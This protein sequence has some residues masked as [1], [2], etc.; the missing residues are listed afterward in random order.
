MA[1]VRFPNGDVIRFPDGTPDEVVR[2]VSDEHWLKVNLGGGMVE[3]QPAGTPAMRVPPSQERMGPMTTGASTET[4]PDIQAEP[5]SRTKPLTDEEIGDRP[6][7]GPLPS[8]GQKAAGSLAQGV[9]HL[10]Y[11][12]VDFALA[13]PLLG[14]FFSEQLLP[15]DQPTPV[16]DALAKGR[17]GV[18]EL[19][20]RMGLGHRLG[21]GEVRGGAAG[22]GDI[23]GKVAGFGVE[24]APYVA[25]EVATAGGVSLP[26]AKQVFERVLTKAMARGMERKAAEAVAKEAA[27]IARTGAAAT[28]FG[29]MGAGAGIEKGEPAEAAKGFAESAAGILAL[30]AAGKLFGFLTRTLR[31]QGF[32]PKAAADKAKVYREA[33]IDMHPDR[34]GPN[35]AE[36]IMREEYVK[37]LQRAI[38]GDDW[39]T[40]DRIISMWKR[41][42]PPPDLEVEAEIAGRMLPKDTATAQALRTEAE[43]VR[44]ET[45][46]AQAAKLEREREITRQAEEQRR[47]QA[48]R[49]AELL[50]AMETEGEPTQ[51]ERIRRMADDLG[52]R[53]TINEVRNLLNVQ[54]REEARELLNAALPE[55]AQ[56]APGSSEAPERPPAPAEPAAEFAKPQEPQGAQPEAIP[57]ERRVDLVRRRRVAE[58]S[59][60][61]AKREL[62]VDDRIRDQHGIEIGNRRAYVEAEHEAP[63]DIT[64]WY[65]VDS[66]GWWNDH[67]SEA[68]GDKLLG[69]IAEES[70]AIREEMGD[71]VRTVTR[72]GGDEFAG[73]FPSEQ[74]AQ[75]F[76]DRLNK[77][78][79][80][81]QLRVTLKDGTILTATPAISHGVGGDYDRAS[82]AGHEHKRQREQE[83][84]RAPKGR[85]PIDLVREASRAGEPPGQAGGPAAAAA[86]EPVAEGEG[87]PVPRAEV[88]AVST[89]P[90]RPESPPHTTDPNDPDFDLEASNRHYEADQEWYRKL[91]A[92]SPEEAARVL[93][94][95]QARLYLK[96]FGTVENFEKSHRF[97]IAKGR[98]DI[99]A[100][101]REEMERL[102]AQ[103]HHLHTRVYPTGS[104]GKVRTDEA[105]DKAAAELL[106]RML[107]AE[108]KEAPDAEGLRGDEGQVRPRGGDELRR[109]AGEG[110][111]DLQREAPE[112]PR[113]EAPQAREGRAE[114]V[115]EAPEELNVGDA[116]RVMGSD[117][118][119]AD[120][121]TIDGVR[122][123]L[124]KAAR[125]KQGFVRVIDLD[126]GNVTAL[127]RFNVYDNARKVHEDAVAHVAPPE[128]PAKEPPE[129][130]KG[131]IIRHKGTGQQGPYKYTIKPGGKP[132]AIIDGEGGAKVW[133]PYDELE[134]VSGT[135]EGVP[136]PVAEKAAPKETKPETE[137]ES[138]RKTAV[139]ELSGG[140]VEQIEKAGY[141][142]HRRGDVRELTREE[143]IEFAG[144]AGPGTIRE[145]W[146][147]GITVLPP[148][149]PSAAPPRVDKKRIAAAKALRSQAKKLASKAQEALD[150]PRKTHTARYARQAESAMESAYADQALA[151]TMQAVA[152]KLESGE[153]TKLANVKTKAAVEALEKELRHANIEHER[154]LPADERAAREEIRSRAPNESD[155]EHATFPWPKMYGHNARYIARELSEML[156]KK[157]VPR[158]QIVRAKQLVKSWQNHAVRAGEDWVR[159]DEAWLD[160]M[161]DTAKLLKSDTAMLQS[162]VAHI[163]RL[164]RLG[165]ESTE[166]LRAAL[167]E[168]LDI[169]SEAKGVSEGKKAELALAGRKIP[170]FFPTPRSVIT[171]ML[172]R[173]DIKSTDRVLEPSAGKGDLADAMVAAGAG[174]GQKGNVDI[175]EFNSELAKI[176]IDKGYDVTHRDFLEYSV[177]GYDKIVMNPPFEKGQDIKHVQHAYRLLKPGGRVVSIMSEGPFFREDYESR[178]FRSWLEEVDGTSEKLPEGS[179]KEHELRKTGV[180]SRIVV[181]DKPKA[182]EAPA[183]AA[184]EPLAE[185]P[186]PEPKKPDA[187]RPTTRGHKT[188]ESSGTP[189]IIT[190]EAHELAK[191]RH[192]DDPKKQG[193]I[194]ATGARYFIQWPDGTFHGE[195]HA[196]LENALNP[197]FKHFGLTRDPAE[198]QAYF[199]EEAAKESLERIKRIGVT[200]RPDL[201][202]PIG[203]IDVVPNAD[204]RAA[205][206]QVEHEVDVKRFGFTKQQEAWIIEQLKENWPK[207]KDDA[208]ATLRLQI[209]GDGI[210]TMGSEGARDLFYTL[211][212]K[213]IERDEASSSNKLTA[214]TMSSGFPGMRRAAGEAGR[215]ETRKRYGQLSPAPLSYSPKAAWMGKDA[216][217]DV[218]G[219][220]YTNGHFLI[221]KKAVLENAP[222]NV[223]NEIKV[224]TSDPKHNIPTKAQLEKL[225]K[226]HANKDGT[227]AHLRG[228]R[229]SLHADQMEPIIETENGAI[230]SEF[231][232]SLDQ[233]RFLEDVTGFD[234]IRFNP[235]NAN[236]VGLWRGNEQV[237]IAGVR[238]TAGNRWDGTVNLEK[239]TDEVFGNDVTESA[240]DM[241]LIETAKD[242]FITVLDN[243]R[244]LGQPRKPLRKLEIP[245]AVK[246]DDPKIEERFQAAKGLQSE[247]KVAEMK[248]LL[249]S[250]SIIFRRHY[251]H[252]DVGKDSMRALMQDELRTLEAAERAAKPIT[253]I[254]IREITEGLDGQ[255]LDLFSRVI[256]LP[257]IIKDVEAGL[258]DTATEGEGKPLPFG[259]THPRFGDNAPETDITQHL[260]RLERIVAANSHVRAALDRRARY[261]RGLTEELVELEILDADVLADPR[262]YHRQVMKHFNARE[263]QWV[264]TGS[265]DVRIHTKGFMKRRVGGT[266]FNTAYQEAE[267]EWAS[268]AAAAIARKRT[269]DRLDELANIKG[270]LN[271]EARH[272]N[273]VNLVGGPENLARIHELRN[274]IAALREEI[275]NGASDVRPI[276]DARATE[277]GEL[278]PLIPYR[279]RIGEM[280]RFLEDQAAAGNLPAGPYPD[281]LG[282]LAEGKALRGAAEDK[283]ITPDYE[284]PEPERFFG[285]LKWLVEHGKEVADAEFKEMFGIP[286]TEADADAM[287]PQVP[288]LAFLKAVNEKN[289]FI[290]DRLG[291]DYLTWENLIPE[292]YV[293][294]QPKQ[295]ANVFRAL[296]I[297]ERAMQR[298][299][300]GEIELTPEQVHTVLAIGGMRPQWVIPEDLAKTLDEFHKYIDD[301]MDNLFR[302]A[303]STWKQTV[304]LGPTR[305]MKYNLNNM[306]GDADICVAFDPQIMKYFKDAAGDLWRYHVKG[307]RVPKPVQEEIDEAMEFGV[308][309]SGLTMTDIPD[310]SKSGA[311][312]ALINE[313]PNK[314][315]DLVDRYWKNVREFTV[316][317]ENILRLAAYR[318]MKERVL[319]SEKYKGAG[320]SRVDE[321]AP[322]T[323]KR[324]AAKLARDLVGDYGAI[325]RGGMWLRENLFSFWS[326]AEI[327]APRYVRLFKNLQYEEGGDPWATG[328][329]VAG[330][331]TKKVGGK[332]LKRVG[333]RVL[334]AHIVSGLVW[335]WNMTLFPD[336][337]REIRRTRRGLHVILGRNDETGEIHAIRFEGAL[338]D[339]LK[340]V[341]LSDWP[342][343][344]EDLVTGRAD[345]RDKVAEIPK[346]AA[347]RTINGV[348][349]FIKTPF[350]LIGGFSTY[351]SIFGEGRRGL[352]PRPIRDRTEHVVRTFGGWAGLDKL[353]NVVMGKPRRTTDLT[354]WQKAARWVEP[355]LVYRTDPREASYWAI[356]HEASKWAE[357]HLNKT[358]PVILHRSARSN[359]L[360]YYRKAL[361]WGDEKR[362]AKWLNEYFKEGGSP[363]G[364]EQSLRTQHPLYTIPKQHRGAFMAG[365]SKSDQELLRDAL[366]WYQSWSGK[367]AF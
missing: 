122:Y 225:W 150:Q 239:K 132:T 361:M 136:A 362:A 298:I 45:E 330:V 339:A 67:V 143:R 65:D 335:L 277:L 252:I 156:E 149:K 151:K 317:R 120:V 185:K 234:T 240:D 350:E 32:N 270:R 148:E 87:A 327:N 321:V 337:E 232:F 340:W 165:I 10:L 191:F 214:H 249:A 25:A 23:A 235:E 326:W 38:E 13:A 306:S 85:E 174:K 324:R 63:D 135:T 216:G 134:V 113:G 256:V 267:L 128:A 142:F 357:E 356:R 184:E 367:S 169:R 286:L 301:P 44:A 204:A 354:G 353:Y 217:L 257:D 123:E 316:W 36:R 266:D 71:R 69:V 319:G 173:A 103:G 164:H 76:A 311:F 56:K 133:I 101:V 119:V 8:A 167:E 5:P 94:Q 105:A 263:R 345:W 312:K 97:W 333:R 359:A 35:N 255:A 264:G 146:K 107:A 246:A 137:A 244:K 112:Q 305:A 21:G 129:L 100:R 18:H 172:E 73:R 162:D 220:W 258:Y 342:N 99:A 182:E 64:L 222:A 70:A 20:Q 147:A 364:L 39:K 126:S 9:T 190:V 302:W 223:K 22:V 292:G 79:Q 329:R 127:K 183:P 159:L 245:E 145:L 40:A 78:L 37:E 229:W 307:E 55:T 187:E 313:D 181:I 49:R 92:L 315:V 237:A 320:V 334:Q 57:E 280:K 271:A 1:E 293:A 155:L 84:L 283:F 358:S 108:K 203:L 131:T 188:P 60:E 114:G 215:P 27:Q 139:G 34:A 276:L 226:D 29:A 195:D 279:H 17:E 274:E 166:D 110:R 288:A 285:Y 322:L 251:P 341:G 247:G 75:E 304:L 31:S 154:S 284:D 43:Q 130:T 199:T 175:V 62:L 281:V 19:L 201:R 260:E 189:E 349:P 12:G 241:K 121:Q 366:I 262:Y 218:E 209:P 308:I 299:L 24:A 68:E 95:E 102:L 90:P 231:T 346:G 332:V 104:E 221:P 125:G 83:G 161:E 253:Y 47:P 46:Q 106:E 236:F 88:E 275:R 265:T 303:H 272:R 228:W 336:E 295:G 212:D 6:S 72:Y 61:E 117:A 314:F 197:E 287:P 171:K 30:H 138:P 207:I 360:Y 300:D 208:T 98:P 261:V 294:W 140:V 213:P 344:V 238:A 338:F 259:Y 180:V 365:L 348:Q 160:E 194:H 54:G 230:I 205:V 310:I 250:A 3:A 153:K 243:L 210:Y 52:R 11:S 26:L 58:M 178:S 86:A 323:G 109:G 2:R 268:Q 168:L 170:G 59:E 328:K 233:W 242:P 211:A 115:K 331:A 157:Q 33:L 77:R 202:K 82:Q 158:G 16:S 347:D 177:E 66:L 352:R 219:D 48:E 81:R 91:F 193:L 273:Y 198:A 14:E 124:Y 50:E 278:D 42:E 351:P 74:D 289:R 118:I 196:S 28:Q 176:L 116:A 15:G 297:E 269:L 290:K 325:S 144:P 111:E 80:E 192:P 152:D 363:K 163:K 200:A 186:K 96:G 89:F 296:T 254:R 224:T 4:V 282:Y 227:R 309:D 179:F 141:T 343:D 41:R 318:R 206:S 53:P 51:G 7:M 291:N 248:K 355:L 93:T